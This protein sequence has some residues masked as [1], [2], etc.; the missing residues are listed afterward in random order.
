MQSALGIG[1]AY[2]Y[3]KNWDGFIGAFD[4]A[5]KIDAKKKTAG[6]A[7][8]GMAWAYFFKKDMAKAEDLAQKAKTEG[9]EDTRLATSIER[10]KKALASGASSVKEAEQ[11]QAEAQ[12]QYDLARQAQKK[13]EELNTSLKVGSPAARRRALG[14]LA[15]IVAPALHALPDPAPCVTIPTGCG[16]RRST[17]SRRIG[18][19]AKIALP[20]IKYLVTGPKIDCL[21]CSKE[22]LQDMMRDEDLRRSAREAVAKIEACR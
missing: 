7:H 3:G 6:E 12:A 4:L 1:W 16:N 10:M 14:S 5:I 18:C 21:Q 19:G 13:V 2:S 8:N 9:R 20:H 11:L 22:E 17:P 15:G